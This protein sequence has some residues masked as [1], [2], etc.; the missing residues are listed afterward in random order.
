MKAI[1]IEPEFRKISVIWYN[2]LMYQ[3][4]SKVIAHLLGGEYQYE[5]EFKNGD[6]LFTRFNSPYDN[7]SLAFNVREFPE[8][9]FGKAL[10][11]SLPSPTYV[12]LHHCSFTLARARNEIVFHSQA[13]TEI[14]RKPYL[15]RAARF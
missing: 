6:G 4:F 13:L 7:E 12:R 1:L 9:F 14:L 10:I 2:S 8:A 5:Y 11:A 15:P 3:D